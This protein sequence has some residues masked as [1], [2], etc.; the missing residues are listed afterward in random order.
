MNKI[1][2]EELVKYNNAKLKIKQN[3][4]SVY[5]KHFLL[6]SSFSK[7]CAYGYDVSK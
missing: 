6:L 1:K 3:E 4:R 2:N 5:L 7:L